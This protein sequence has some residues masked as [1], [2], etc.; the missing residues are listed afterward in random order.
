MGKD[1][2][3][4]GNLL[5]LLGLPEEIQAGL[6]SDAISM[7][8]ARALLS[9]DDSG[10][11][12]ELYRRAAKKGLSVRQIEVLARN[13]APATRRRMQLV[14]PHGKALEDELRRALGTKVEL[15]GRKKGGRIV[16]E[17]FSTEDL[18]RILSM[19]GVSVT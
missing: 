11:Q 10:R 16:I 15:R 13:A 2:S 8:H 19:L 7:G 18:T 9:V 5:R 14:D 6:R 12:V 17:Y 3:T 1:R 4:V